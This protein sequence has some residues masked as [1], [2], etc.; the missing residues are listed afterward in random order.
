LDLLQLATCNVAKTG[1]RAAEVVWCQ[2][3]QAKLGRVV[4]NNMPHHSVGYEIAPGLPSSAN[5]PKE[6]SAGDAIRGQPIVDHMLY[7]TGNRDSANVP[8]FSCQVNYGPMVFPTLE[9]IHL[10]FGQFASAQSA[11]QKY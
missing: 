4:F 10:Q 8:T 11:G 9:I 3:R 1:A 6:L 7:P 5:T 2:L